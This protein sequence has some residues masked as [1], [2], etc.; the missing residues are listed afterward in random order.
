MKAT[1]N[2]YTGQVTLYAWNQADRDDP[3]APDPVLATWEKAFP[4]VVQAAER[5]AARP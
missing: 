5:H 2:A 4:G 3:D 1:V